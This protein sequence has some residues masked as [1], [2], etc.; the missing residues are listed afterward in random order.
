VKTHSQRGFTL[1][2]LLVVIAIIGILTTIAL[3]SFNSARDRARRSK[4]LQEFGSLRTAGEL[5]FASDGS[6]SYMCGNS[7]VQGFS[8]FVVYPGQQPPLQGLTGL[9]TESVLASLGE[10][11]DFMRCSAAPGYWMAYSIAEQVSMSDLS[12]VVAG[13]YPVVC[14]DSTGFAG[15]LTEP[16]EII[17]AITTPFMSCSE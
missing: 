11:S 13:E 9:E 4:L 14:A 1:I 5:V 17:T 8:V 7:P 16:S 2:E 10:A 15:I 3:V 12:G 6:Y